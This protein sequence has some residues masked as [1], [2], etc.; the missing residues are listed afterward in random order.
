MSKT[1]ILILRLLLIYNICVTSFSLLNI[2]YKLCHNDIQRV[3]LKIWPLRSAESEF[4]LYID[5]RIQRS[6]VGLLHQDNPVRNIKKEF[7]FY[8]V[9]LV[10]KYS[11]TYRQMFENVVN[12]LQN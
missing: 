6:P 11:M 3:F 8:I 10:T 7:N 2:G 4:L 12:Y 9:L 1:K 5:K